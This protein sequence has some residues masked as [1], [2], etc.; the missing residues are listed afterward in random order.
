MKGEPGSLRS[1]LALFRDPATAEKRRILAERW[2]GLDPA[3]RLPGQGLGQK[4]TGCGATLGIQPRCDFA[5]TGCY[6][7][8][9]ANHIPA[10]PTAA[11]LRQLDA[12]RQWLGPK[13]NVQITDGE[14]TLRPVEE[15]V[16]I[17]SYARS[18]GVIP[19]VMTHGDNF[20]RQPGLLER[21]MVEGGLTEVS[22]HVDITQRGRDGHK[23]PKSELE[24][25]GLREE[26]AKMVREARRRTGRTL[27]AAMTLTVTQ[28][29]LPQ[30]PAV[31][32][33][34]IH[35][36]DA[37][38]LVS[39]QPL[40]QVGRTRKSQ[41]GVTADELWTEIAKATAD[42]GLNLQGVGPMHFGHTECTRFVPLL[43]LERP[44]GDLRALQL[45]RDEPED[46]AIMSEF[47]SRGLGGMAF[48]DD[49]PLEMVGRALGFARTDPR[50]LL[51]RVRRWATGRFRTEAGTSLGRLLVDSLRG[52]IRL[53]GFTLTS[54]HFMNPAELQT[55]V[56][57]ARLAAC[58]FR[59][60]YRGEMIPMCQMNADGVRE[61]FYA[62]ITASEM[63]LAERRPL[64]VVH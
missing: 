56:G 17:L 16:E 32:R 22:I 35:N 1:F 23:A 63:E 36:H 60:P 11:I 3:L 2:A 28:E 55:Q 54:H 51:G 15:L 50:W 27:R 47:F 13:S 30:I 34:L 57:Q 52:K 7:G 46:V 62:G 64:P 44:G 40:A 53:G 8:H 43:T 37:F 26:F 29:N 41:H 12:M 58:V 14:V 25:M 49:R 4:A 39:F 18:I 45:I 42:F 19:M 61:R 33:W 59:L 5:C 6:L 24:L 31:V 10:L 9:E 38:S 20:R 48:R 21:L